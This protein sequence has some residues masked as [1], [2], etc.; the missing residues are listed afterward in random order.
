MKESLHLCPVWGML[1]RHARTK[2]DRALTATR[3]HLDLSRPNS[4]SSAHKY[5]GLRLWIQKWHSKTCSHT[6]FSAAT[7]GMVESPEQQ[8]FVGRVSLLLVCRSCDWYLPCCPIVHREYA[9]RVSILSV[10]LPSTVVRRDASTLCRPTI[11]HDLSME[12]PLIHRT[13]QACHYVSTLEEEVRLVKR[14]QL[15]EFLW[16]TLCSRSR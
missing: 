3:W 12:N 16:L 2:S 5:K 1:R 7:D 9:N 10:C 6:L 15:T 13:I 11:D 8:A 14:D 4:P